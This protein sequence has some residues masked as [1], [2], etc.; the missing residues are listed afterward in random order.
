MKVFY[1][2]PFLLVLMNGAKSQVRDS[3]H[4]VMGTVVGND[5]VI[6]IQVKEI[7]VFPERK[8]TSKKQQQNYSRYVAKV[9]KVYPQLKPRFCCKNTNHNTTRST[10]SAN[11][12]N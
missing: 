10:A 2:L 9:K 7:W 1:I 11:A 8:F 5:T 4:Y 6:Q 12:E 3:T